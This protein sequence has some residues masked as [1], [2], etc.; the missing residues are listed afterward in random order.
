VEFPK[1]FDRLMD[2]ML[3]NETVEI[4]YEKSGYDNNEFSVREISPIR[5][6]LVERPSSY[7]HRICVEAHC[8]LRNDKRVFAVH[9]ITYVTD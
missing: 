5:F 8:H 9:R 3:S 4:G 1:V 2:A 6:V 7:Y